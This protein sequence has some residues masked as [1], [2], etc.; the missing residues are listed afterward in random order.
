MRAW[1]CLALVGAVVGQQPVTLGVGQYCPNASWVS[2]FS[3]PVLGQAYTL[4][5]SRWIVFTDIN[6]VYSCSGV[7]SVCYGGTYPYCPWAAGT[8]CY[9]GQCDYSAANCISKSYVTCYFSRDYYMICLPGCKAAASCTNAPA[10]SYYTGPSSTSGSNACPWSC[11]DNAAYNG[12]TCVCN[13]GYFLSGSTCY[14]NA[15]TVVRG[16]ACAEAKCDANWGVFPCK[17]NYFLFD[18]TYLSTIDSV[19][20]NFDRVGVGAEITGNSHLIVSNPNASSALVTVD[21]YIDTMAVD[22]YNGVPIYF[23]ISNSNTNIFSFQDYYAQ[24]ATM[25]PYGIL[26]GSITK[27]YFKISYTFSVPGNSFYLMFK[28][29]FTDTV[30]YTNVSYAWKVYCIPCPA[31][32]Y[33]S[34]CTAS[35]T[36]MCVSCP[37]N[38][39]CSSLSIGASS[40]KAAT[41]V[42]GATTTF[43]P[44]TTSV[45]C[46]AGSF[47]NGTQCSSCLV[48]TYSNAS[49]TVCTSCPTYTYASI[50]NA[51]ACLSCVPCWSGTFR[52]GCGGSSPGACTNC[53][54][55][56]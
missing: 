26:I 1:L 15:N 7:E 27:G 4:P 47:R 41:T 24:F 42:A 22:F 49:A 29:D 6:H 2:G 53:T 28:G 31:N 52:S 3:Y 25:S 55:T 39:G 54:N 16:S 10:N 34:G 37:A 38:T 23:L 48:G 46:L 56:S 44:T 9:N 5:S 45:S 33:A 13:S 50:S 19:A 17:S 8:S 12:A 43:I 14:S 11:I 36:G 40:C 51:T 18:Y 21:A 30:S 35:N 20:C 32:Q